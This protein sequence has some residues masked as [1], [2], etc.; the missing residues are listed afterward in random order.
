MV[1]ALFYKPQGGGF[2]SP[3]G[4][5]IFFQFTNYFQPHHG[6]GIYSAS[7][8]MSTRKI[9]LGSRACPA[10]KADNLYVYLWAEN[11]GS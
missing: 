3:L 1:E 5:W 6:P 11:V 7:N 9:F 4:N 10:R 2:E 8:E